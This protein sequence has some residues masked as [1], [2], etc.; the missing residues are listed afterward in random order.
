MHRRPGPKALA[1]FAAVSLAAASAPVP[2]RGWTDPAWFDGVRFHQPEKSTTTS[3]EWFRRT[4]A[5]QRGPWR[6]FTDTTP[7]P[8]PPRCVENGRLR[9]TFINHS[10][11]LLQMDGLNI[12][13][14]PTWSERS[15]PAVGAHRRRP[16]GLRF[17][18]LPPIDAVLVSHDHHDHM[19]LPTLS[20]LEAAWHP[21]VFTG[22]RNGRILGGH[23]IGRVHELGWWQTAEIAPGVTVT[24]V[25]ARHSSGRNPLK[26]NR[27]LWCGFVVSGPSGSIYFAGDTGWGA[28][29]APIGEAFPRLRLALLPIGGFLPVW[30]MREQHMGPDDAVAVE[31]LLNAGTVVPMHFGTFPNAADG[32]MEPAET[33]RRALAHAPD[34]SPHFS[35][36]D[37]GDSLEV[38]P[39]SVESNARGR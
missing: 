4:F 3:G 20:R 32:E 12:L 7:G 28:H 38:P 23:G 39:V 33:L 18:D 13:T 10:T 35:I 16:P 37:N 22:L 21:A 2:P 8:P 31:R 36:L 34:V 11:F 15:A 30:Y 27:T 26:P 25:P 24:A 14:D 17:E 19:D 6:R 1:L 9:V 29:F 5:S